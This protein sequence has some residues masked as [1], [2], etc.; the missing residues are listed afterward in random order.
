MPTES[1]DLPPP[2]NHVFVDYENVHHIDSAIIGDAT[3]HFTLLLGAQ[4]TKLD[5]TLV[6]KLL[7]HAPTIEWVR[8][9]HLGPNAVD[10]ALAYYVGRAAIA[11]PCGYFHIVSKDKGYDA[12]IEHL[13]S[14]HIRA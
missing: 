8:L 11:N 7:L 9:K 6:E 12:L 13:R 10:F 5:A 4:K 14:K 1:K 2:V 3:V